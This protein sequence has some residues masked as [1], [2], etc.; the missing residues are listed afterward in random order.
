M[1]FFPL[2]FV[3]VAAG[4]MSSYQAVLALVAQDRGS[5]LWSSLL[6][7]AWG[8][9]SLSVLVEIAVRVA[10]EVRK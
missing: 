3:V 10:K 1:R 4:L 2:A 6:A 9:I 7:C 5:F 8:A